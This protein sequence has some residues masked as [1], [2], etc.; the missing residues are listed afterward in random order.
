MVD[1]FACGYL[2]VGELDIVGFDVEVPTLVDE[3]GG[4]GLLHF[5]FS[6]EAVGYEGSVCGRMCR[7]RSGSVS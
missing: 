2:S 7:A 6:G 4:D 3:L 5:R 1:N